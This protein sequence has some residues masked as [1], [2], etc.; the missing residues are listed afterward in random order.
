MSK[1]IA[2]ETNLTTADICQQLKKLESRRVTTKHINGGPSQGVVNQLHSKQSYW[3]KKGR[4]GGNS[5]G[6]QNG[7]KPTGQQQQ[8]KQL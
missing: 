5:H 4:N 3:G 6:N 7:G 1:C 2:E 8:Q